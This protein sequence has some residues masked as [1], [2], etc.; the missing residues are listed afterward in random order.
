MCEVDQDVRENHGGLG[1]VVSVK[2]C[3]VPIRLAHDRETVI[4]S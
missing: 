4:Y 1:T 2:F 3:V